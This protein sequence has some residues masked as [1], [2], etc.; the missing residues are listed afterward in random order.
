[1]FSELNN[2]RWYKS[3]TAEKKMQLATQCQCLQELDWL[4][5][6]EG[7]YP[8]DS[9]AHNPT[10]K[11]NYCCGESQV[12]VNKRCWEKGSYWISF[13]LPTSG[14]YKIFLKS[15]VCIVRAAIQQEAE[16]E[17][18]VCRRGRILKGF[19]VADN[20]TKVTSALRYVKDGGRK[21]GPWNTGSI[22]FSSSFWFILSLR[23]C[24]RTNTERKQKNQTCT[25]GLLS[26]AF[27]YLVILCVNFIFQLLFSLTEQ[28]GL[29]NPRLSLSSTAY[30]NIESEQARMR[31]C[32]N[33][34]H[35]A[36]SRWHKHTHKSILSEDILQDPLHVFITRFTKGSVNWLITLQWEC[37]CVSYLVTVTLHHSVD[38]LLHQISTWTEEFRSA[39]A[40]KHT[41]HKSFYEKSRC[42]SGSTSGSRRNARRCTMSRCYI[43]TQECVTY[44]KCCICIKRCGCQRKHKMTPLHHI[45]TGQ[46]LLADSVRYMKESW[47]HR[48]FSFCVSS[49]R[50]AWQCSHDGTSSCACQAY[51]LWLR[52]TPAPPWPVTD[53]HTHTHTHLLG[54][55]WGWLLKASQQFLYSCG[56]PAGSAGSLSRPLTSISRHF[57]ICHMQ[58]SRKTGTGSLQPWGSK[59]KQQKKGQCVSKQ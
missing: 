30:V 20:Q 8:E 16:R 23:L 36:R 38:G 39:T 45:M 12:L 4:I 26:I 31:M 33:V 28:S 11:K 43:S 41:K 5:E 22:F 54:V 51:K 1:M 49:P 10:S 29:V 46:T 40:R 25:R 44:R 6:N 47:A 48:C 35:K 2:A 24:C 56:H 9:S 14:G 3:T 53:T 13:P 37:V 15:T 59:D 27:G 17:K 50:P 58:P 18:T 57:L 52:H 32:A 21:S 55:F 19:R 34:K 7:M 42:F